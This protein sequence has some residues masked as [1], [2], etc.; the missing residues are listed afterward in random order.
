[1]DLH[2]LSYSTC[3][4]QKMLHLTLNMQTKHALQRPLLNSGYYSGNDRC[5]SSNW[6]INVNTVNKTSRDT[7]IYLSAVLIYTSSDKLQALLWSTSLSLHMF[8]SGSRVP[9]VQLSNS[10]NRKYPTVSTVTL[11]FLPDQVP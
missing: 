7:C 6:D 1:M 11:T 10:D 9:D 2:S 4:N 3:F 8:G 5:N